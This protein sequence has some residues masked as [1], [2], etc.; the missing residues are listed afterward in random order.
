MSRM[1]P[2]HKIFDRGLGL[3]RR[4]R[5]AAGAREVDF[6][7]ARVAEDFIER[8]S[9]TR[10]TFP[11]AASIGAYHGA[12]AARLIGI[13]G[14]ETMVT[15]EHAHNLLAQAPG[16]KVQADDEALR[17]ETKAWIWC[18]PRFRSSSQTICRA[19]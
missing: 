11:V 18:C 10:R 9:V 4:Q 17:F 12:I 15:V 6:L 2:E 7:L 8:L 13:S 14:I 19:C 1:A 3:A 16:L 5:M